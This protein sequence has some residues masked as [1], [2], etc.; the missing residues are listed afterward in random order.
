MDVG[1]IT[2]SR[3]KREKKHSNSFIMSLTGQGSL[4][5]ERK[6]KRQLNLNVFIVI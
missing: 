4:H 1:S 5:K 2:K 6:L 3:F